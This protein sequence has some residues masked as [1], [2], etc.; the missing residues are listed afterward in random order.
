MS[1]RRFKPLFMAIWAVRKLLLWVMQCVSFKIVVFDNQVPPQIK[2]WPEPA[3]PEIM[4][5][6]RPWAEHSRNCMQVIWG[7]CFKIFGWRVISHLGRPWG[8]FSV[9]ATQLKRLLIPQWLSSNFHVGYYSTMT[10][11]NIKYSRRKA[12]GQNSPHLKCEY[13]ISSHSNS[14]I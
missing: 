8:Y 5:W 14:T 2:D 11:L 7:Y 12:R 4:S 13:F 6:L 10:D 1:I 3:P 9:A